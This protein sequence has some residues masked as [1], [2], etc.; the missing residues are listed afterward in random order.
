MTDGSFN[1]GDGPG[2]AGRVSRSKTLTVEP[3]KFEKL[4]FSDRKITISSKIREPTVGSRWDKAQ[5]TRASEPVKMSRSV[6]V[7]DGRFVRNRENSDSSQN[8]PRGR[9]SDLAFV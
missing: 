4:I 1:A 7:L 8:A 6:T 2:G 9:G 5:S 3:K